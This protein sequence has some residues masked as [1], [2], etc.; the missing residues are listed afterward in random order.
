MATYVLVHGA[1]SGAHSFRFVRPLLQAD[2]HEVFTPSLTGIGERVH[3]ASP[4]VT[5]STHVDDVV[6]QVLFEDLDD[7]VLLG[8][9]YG[10]A[11]V[12]AAL[13]H[14]ADR[15]AHLVF[16]DAF[17][18]NDG[19]SVVD[20]TPFHAPARAVDAPWALP[21]LPREYD[22]PSLGAWA[23]PR[24]VPQPIA[25]FTEPVRL[26]RRLEE[27]PFTRTFI[28]ATG[29]ARDDAGDPFWVF[30]DR[31]R[32]HPAWSYREIDTDHMIPFNRPT[33]LADLL[34]A[35]VSP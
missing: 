15:V 29:A 11:V 21:A 17:V 14:L 31:F 20:L 1:W 10:G 24:R 33:E 19:Q 35:L 9:S 4:Q 8:F 13:R 22:D 3:L 5:L 6:N 23:E 18:P 30:A 25:T 32:G 12:T 7:I 26:D 2:G 16:L 27:H 28:K 34:G